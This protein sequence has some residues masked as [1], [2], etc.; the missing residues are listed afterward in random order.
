VRRFFK[1]VDPVLG[2]EWIARNV[3]P[4]WRAL[5]EPIVMDWDS[6]VQPKYG[7]QEAAAV[8][9]NPSKPGRASFHPLLAVIAH[10]RLCPVYCFRRGDTVTASE[11]EEAMG[12][13]QRW[14]DERKVWLNRG[15]LGV[16][17]H[18]VSGTFP[19][20]KGGDGHVV[21]GKPCGAWCL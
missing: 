15:N 18:A 8:G 2:A 11:W 4:M 21:S 16:P 6:M 1:S 20:D 3:E 9:Y 7:H 19:H 5:P 17:R 14:L 13:A 12:D 10:T